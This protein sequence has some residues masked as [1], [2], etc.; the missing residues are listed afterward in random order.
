M[1]KPGSKI[2]PKAVIQLNQTEILLSFATEYSANKP[3][4]NSK[5]QGYGLGLSGSVSKVY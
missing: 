5:M 4:G 2:L 3:A 1:H